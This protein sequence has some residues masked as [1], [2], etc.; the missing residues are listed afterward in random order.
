VFDLDAYLE[1]IG[2]DGRPTV[3]QVHRAHAI[4]I[5]FENLDPR[6]GVPASL[7]VADLERKLVTERRGGYCFEHNLLLAEALIALGCEVDLM[8]ARPR[9]RNPALDALPTTRPQ[10]H[11]ALRVTD[12]DGAVWHADVGFG[13]GTPLRPLRWGPGDEHEIDGWRYRVVSEGDEYVLQSE[14]AGAW[15]DLYVMDPR[16]VLRVDYETS[17]WLASTYPRHPMVRGLIVSANGADGSRVSVSDWSGALLL[18][19]QRPGGEPMVT[20]LTADEVRGALAERFGLDAA[21]L[22]GYEPH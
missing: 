6:R 5:P 11:C 15:R 17:N 19:E 13:L 16:P 8:L 2:L 1:R 20:A 9:M 21:L 12:A 10:T 18:T 3:E 22:D 7:H 14:A 4:A